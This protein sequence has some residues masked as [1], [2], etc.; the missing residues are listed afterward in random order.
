MH[1]TLNP[2]FSDKIMQLE[3]LLKNSPLVLTECAISERIR[4]RDNITLHPIL[5][6]TPLIYDQ[7]EAKVLEDIYFSYRKVASK[8][9]LPLILCAPTWRVDQERVAAAKGPATINEDAVKF[10]SHLKKN[11]QSPDSPIIVGALLAPK[12][13]C[14]QPEAALAREEAYSFHSWQIEKLVK[15]GPDVIIAQTMPAVGEALGMADRLGESKIPYIISFVI[16]R[17][18]LVLDNTPLAEAIETMDQKLSTPPLGYMVNCVYPTFINAQKQTPALFNR[19]IG[20]QAN[21][22]SKDHEQLDGADVL[23]Q[24]PISEWGQDML[25]LHRDYGVKILGGCCGTDHEHLRYLAENR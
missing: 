23:Q 16:N 2:L 6:N 25:L 22:S 15:A 3:H 10:M 11:W 8:S 21:A 14:Y 20:I 24:N 13:D 9:H 1:Y 18:G 7:R 5:F 17:S 19:L 4:R 12:N